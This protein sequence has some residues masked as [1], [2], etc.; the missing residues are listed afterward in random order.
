M[1]EAATVEVTVK[2]R[3]GVDEQ[4]PREVLPDF[5]DRIRSAGIRRVA[6][7]AR[8]A[9]LEGLSP[10]ENRT[11][12]PLDHDLVVAMKQAFPDLHISVNGGIETLDQAEAFL[13]RGL[14]GVM[15]GRAAYHTPAAILLEADARIWGDP[16]AGRTAEDVV[17][18]MLPY[19]ERHLSEGGRLNQ[20]TRHMLGLFAGRPGARAWRRVLSEGAHRPGAGSDLVERALA[21]VLPLAA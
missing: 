9:W 2:C 17:R 15:I 16:P 10:R 19:I 20:V 4:E 7:H 3:I 21:E 14:D 8:K 5:L 12:P 11:V 13:A 1:I 18:D 6:I